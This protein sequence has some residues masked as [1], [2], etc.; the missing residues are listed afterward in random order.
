[1]NKFK[2]KWNITCLSQ[3]KTFENVV[4]K[5]AVILFRLQCVVAS[6]D[7]IYFKQSAFVTRN[8]IG[9]IFINKEML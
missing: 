6:S 3:E 9:C 1:M 7:G 4:C 8:A 5:M 2:G